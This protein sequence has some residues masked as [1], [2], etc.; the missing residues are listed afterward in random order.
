MTEPVYDSSDY[1]LAVDLADQMGISRFTLYGHIRKGFVK[2]ERI[3]GRVMIHKVE[4]ARHHK[5]HAATRR[6]P[7]TIKFYDKD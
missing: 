7:R 6:R 4:A 3:A 1:V 2:A 5:T